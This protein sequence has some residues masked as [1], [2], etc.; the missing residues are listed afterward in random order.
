MRQL[1]V[2][3]EKEIGEIFVPQGLIKKDHYE[4]FLIE[5][6]D[7]KE[8]KEFVKALEELTGT[9]KEEMLAPFDPD[10]NI[11][12]SARLEEGIYETPAVGGKAKVFERRY[13]DYKAYVIKIVEPEERFDIMNP[14]DVE[15]HGLHEVHPFEGKFDMKSPECSGCG[16]YKW[17]YVTF[18]SPVGDPDN[19][20]VLVAERCCCSHVDVLGCFKGEDILSLPMT[21]KAKIITDLLGKKK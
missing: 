10:D 15:E 20:V 13:G 19:K 3:K 1:Q 2:T 17:N 12:V 5:V 16:N 4:G 11:L 14:Y 18:I 8:F 6:I 21:E 7:P 9:K